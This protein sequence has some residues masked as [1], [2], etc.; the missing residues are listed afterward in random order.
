MCQDVHFLVEG[1]A[2]VQLVHRKVP[3]NF[4]TC[5]HRCLLDYVDIGVYWIMALSKE[6]DEVWN[7]Q[8]TLQSCLCSQWRRQ[9]PL[10]S[11][12]ELET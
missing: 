2:F 5:E 12:S 3:V 11:S 4:C 1:T 9:V 7:T 10:E 6:L 8:H